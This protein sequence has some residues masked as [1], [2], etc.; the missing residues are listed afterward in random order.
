MVFALV[1]SQNKE[2]L[3]FA[4]SIV[5]STEGEGNKA[6]IRTQ[7][8]T[9]LP[10]GI[11]VQFTGADP[12]KIPYKF[13]GPRFCFAEVGFSGSWEKAFVSQPSFTVSYAALNGTP[14]KHEVSLN[15]FGEAY[16]YYS[17]EM[18]RQSD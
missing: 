11:S 18:T 12:V 17:Q 14:L 2:Q 15:Q 1:N 5:P 8:G 13:C 16:A 4:W 10:E 3:I 6:V 7:T 9:L